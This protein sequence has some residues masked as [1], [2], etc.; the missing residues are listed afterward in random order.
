MTGHRYDAVYQHFLRLFV[1]TLGG[2]PGFVSLIAATLFF[3]YAIGA[4]CHWRG[5]C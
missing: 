1:S 4:V 5:N 2:S 3:V